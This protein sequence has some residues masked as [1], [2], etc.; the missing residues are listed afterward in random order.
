VIDH[1]PASG[2]FYAPVDLDDP[3]VVAQSGLT[4]SESNPQFHQQMVYAVAMRIIRDFESAL[5]RLVLWAPRRPSTPREEYV[6]QLRIHPHALREANAY[7]SP[8]RRALLFGYFPAPAGVEGAGGPRLTVF[9]CLS[10]DIVAHEVT[11]AILDGIH[12]R[13]AEPTNPDVLAFHEAFADIVAL[14]E[15]FSLA[16]VL[17]HQIAETRGDL[18]SQNRLGDWPSSSAAPSGSGARC[19][20]PSAP[21]TRAPT[22]G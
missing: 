17:V 8:D 15:H 13:F 1:D 11:H 14:F 9:T 20:A 19:A 12:R 22:R 18:A 10:H 6:P 21:P 4:P 16:D 3:A 2:C 5:G 7:Y